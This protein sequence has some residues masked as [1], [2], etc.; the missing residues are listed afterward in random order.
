LDVDR[1]TDRIIGAAMRVHRELGPGLLESTYE[2]CMAVELRRC[3]LRFDQ[4]HPLALVYQGVLIDCAYRV[5]LMVE[6]QV[7]VE[8]KSVA[9]LE[10][11]HH[12]Q[13][14]TY[15]RLSGC[16]V[17][18]LINFNVPLLK[19]GIRRLVLGPRTATK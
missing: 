17:G 12:A 16:W 3:G 11:V 2:A 5:D 1:I 15:L 19:T 7:P 18:L 8:I 14:L 10:P 9:S 13:L 6:A 4:Q